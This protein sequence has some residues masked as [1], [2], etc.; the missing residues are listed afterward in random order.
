MGF[1]CDRLPSMDALIGG[2]TKDR[3]LLYTTGDGSNTLPEYYI[4]KSDFGTGTIRLHRFQFPDLDSDTIK[5]LFTCWEPA[6]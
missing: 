3:I 6:E 5:E 2:E 1:P 4:E